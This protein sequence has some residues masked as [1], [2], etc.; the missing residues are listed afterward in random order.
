VLHVTGPIDNMNLSYTSDPPLQFQEIVA[1]LASGKTPTS[2]PTLLANQPQAP[3]Q[4]VQQM[5]ES[6]VLSKAVAEPVSNQL[7]R[8][9]GVTQFKIDP[10]F[11]A[12]TSVPTARLTLQQQI[13]SN[14]T[15]TYTSAL[16]DPNG[17]I[18]KVEWT[19]TPEWAAVANRDQNGIFSINFLYRRQFR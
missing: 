4:S 2:D 6:A 14:L 5:G 12:G 7:A 15:F 8:V 9:F 10:S 11:T 18:I 3:S 17:Q 1:L 13:T 16:D 19:F